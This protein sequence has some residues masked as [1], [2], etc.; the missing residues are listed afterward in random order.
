MQWCRKDN[1]CTIV[2][3]MHKVQVMVMV[4]LQGLVLVLVKKKIHIPG[5][6]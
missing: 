3:E 5:K 6:G 4:I 2:E 1:Y